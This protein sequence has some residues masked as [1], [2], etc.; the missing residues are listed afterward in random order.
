MN[1]DWRG[2]REALTRRYYAEGIYGAVT[3][4][5]AMR[6]GAAAHPDVRMIFHSDE[7]PGEATLA[8]MH[9]FSERRYFIA[10]KKFSDLMESM[11]EEG[12]IDYDHGEGRATLTDKGKAYVEG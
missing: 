4:A 6:T 8:E 9:D 5:D 12:Q 10:H 1:P 2:D 3:L 7:H 11:I